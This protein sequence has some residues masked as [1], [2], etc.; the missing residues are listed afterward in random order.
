LIFL[1]ELKSNYEFD[2]FK[3]QRGYTSFGKEHA[4]GK[5]EGDLKEFWHFGQYLN[6]NNKLNFNYPDNPYVKEIPEF[7]SSGEITYKALEKTG[8]Y[9]LRAIALFLNL[10]EN[11]FDKYV[12]NG[13]SILR[14][15]H[16]P[17]ITKEPKNAV[18]AAAHG[19]INLITLVNGCSWKRITGE[20]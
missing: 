7:N 5:K 16:Y 14:P 13:N 4:K 3:G 17:P 2:G 19:D 1:R 6:S 9:V 12:I 18:R 20:K 10:D 8:M 15:I 11:H